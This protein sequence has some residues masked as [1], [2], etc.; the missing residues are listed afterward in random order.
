MMNTTIVAFHNERIN[1]W[2]IN[3]LCRIY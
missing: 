3:V 2:Y 1:C